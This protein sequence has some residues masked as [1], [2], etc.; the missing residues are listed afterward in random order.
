MPGPRA[1]DYDVLSFDCYG[2][3]VD[4]AS[5]IAHHLQGV[6]SGHGVAATDRF[7]LDFFAD[8]EPAVQAEGGRYVDVLAEVM[9]RLARRLAFTPG[10]GEPEEFALSVGDWPPFPDTVNSLARLAERFELVVVSNVDNYL[11]ARTERRLSVRFGHVVTAEDV[12]AYKPN[13]AMFDAA[14][15]AIG[16]GRS[17][18]HVAQSLFHDIAPAAELGLDTAWIRRDQSAARIVEARPTWSYPTLAGFTEAILGRGVASGAAS[19]TSAG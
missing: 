14:M 10:E 8:T 1:V 17:V 4:W 19:E 5:G 2:T 15:A 7:L 13:R 18:L 9:R 6:L 12:G 11:F 16:P 3:L